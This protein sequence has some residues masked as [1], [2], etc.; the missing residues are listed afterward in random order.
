MRALLDLLHD[1]EIFIYVLIGLIS[2]FYI[3]RFISAW[4]EGR[5]A[6]YGLEKE[7]AGQHMRA[8][9]SILVALMVLISLM[10]LTITFVRPMLP[11]VVVVATPTPEQP[12]AQPIALNLGQ[13][14]DITPTVEVVGNQNCIAGQIEL[15][16]PQ[17]GAEL[18]GVITLKGIINVTDFGFYKYEYAQPGSTTWMIIAANGTLDPE[19]TLGLWDTSLLVPGD[20]FLRLVVTDNRSNVVGVCVVGVI[21]IGEG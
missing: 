19:G 17:N 14:T 6:I 21:V 8:N 4:Q 12:T 7:M 18:I 1:Y 16:E 15:S 9:A 20:Y 2:I 3:R 11:Q 10:F 5:L 13:V